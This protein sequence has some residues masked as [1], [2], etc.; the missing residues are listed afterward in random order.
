V[1]QDLA[2]PQA[3]QEL[4]DPIEACRAHIFTISGAFQREMEPRPEQTRE[5]TPPLRM[6]SPRVRRQCERVVGFEEVPNR[7]GSRTERNTEGNIPS[8]AVGEEN[9][10]RE[11]NLPPLLAA[12][13]GRNEN[14]QPLQSS[15]AS[16]HVGRQFSINIEWNLSPNGSILNYEDLKA[17]FRSYFS[18]QKRFMKTYL[19]VHSIKQREGESVKA[20]STSLSKSLREILT[21]EKVARSF[22]QPPRMLGSRRS[23]DMS[24]CCY[25]HEDYGYDTNDCR[26]LRSQI[27]EA[28]KSGQL[29]HLVKG[30]KKEMA[31]TSDSQRGEKKEKSTTSAEAPILMTNQEEACTRNNISKS[32][33]FEGR[34]IT[35]PL[36]T[37]G[38]NSSVPVVIKAKIFGREVGQAIG[39]VLLEI[40][41]GDAPLSRSETLNFI[42]V[43]SNSPIQYAVR[44]DRECVKKIR[45]TSPANTEGVLSCT[46]AEEKIIVNNKYP[47]QTVTIIKQ[48]REHFKESLHQRLLPSARDRLEGEWVYCYQKRPFGLKNAGATYQRLLDKVFNDEIRR[49]LE[50]YVDD[51]VIKSTLEEY[52]LTDIKET[53]QRF[54]SIN[55]KLNPKKCSFGIEEGPFLGYLV[56]KQGIRANPSKVKAIADTE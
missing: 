46:D 18:Q 35:F 17:N 27:E 22:E 19:A 40:T 38:S 31:K 15:L 44:K 6:R 20:F 1:I 28:M 53:F 2:I 4:F 54:R 52:M 43:R 39:E 12:H 41:I 33:T 25:F 45:E 50:A 5:V 48:L 23:R 24:K 3:S 47:E 49:N 9:G 14:G 7:E 51:M 30:I 36:V 37:K 13:L 8:E 55:M 21:I 11:M 10:R 29:S 34:E 26:Q 32:P 16:F 56:T 42:I